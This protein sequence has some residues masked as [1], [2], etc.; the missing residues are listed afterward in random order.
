MRWLIVLSVTFAAVGCE[1]PIVGAKC[2]AGF[3]R[4]AD[5]CVNLQRDFRNCGECG[6]LCQGFFCFKGECADDEP[7]DASSAV[8]AASE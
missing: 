6:N 7:A 4:C 5:E 3:T 8:D 1:S 2:Q